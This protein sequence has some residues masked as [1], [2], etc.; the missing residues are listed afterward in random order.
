MSGLFGRRFALVPLE[1]VRPEGFRETV[2]ERTEIQPVLDYETEAPKEIEDVNPYQWPNPLAPAPVYMVEAPP[3]DRT[4]TDWAPQT[5]AVGLSASQIG[6]ASRK[7]VRLLVRNLDD[8]NDVYIVR[9]Q[10]DSVSF[11]YTIPPGQEAEL[12]HSAK[13]FAFASADDTE[14]SVLAE[15]DV[16]DYAE[17]GDG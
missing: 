13:V 2:P 6:D 14:I 1:P 12:T 16:D 3:F 10:T 5:L 8:A 7:R 11:A 9:Q 4:F 17:A 15:F